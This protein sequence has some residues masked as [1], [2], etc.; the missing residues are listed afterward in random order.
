MIR[1]EVPVIGILSSWTPIS[2]EEDLAA[3]FAVQKFENS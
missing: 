1:A 2:A 3:R